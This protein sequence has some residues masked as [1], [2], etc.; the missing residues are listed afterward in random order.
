MTM[1]ALV[2]PEVGKIA[3]REKNIPEPGPDDVLVKTTA[4]LVCTSDIH[5]VNGGLPVADGVTLG[6]EAAGV[7]AAVGANVTGFREGDRVLAPAVTPC[8]ECRYC[9]GGYPSQ[10]GGMLGGYRYTAQVDGNMSEYFIVP[11]ARANLA[12]IPEGVSDSEAVYAA[13]MLSTGFMGAENAH[14]RLGDTVAVFAMGPVGLSAVIGCALQGASRIFAVETR[15]ERQKLA[16]IY[17]ATDII[18]FEEGDPVQQILAATSGEGVDAA[19]E[20]LGSPHTWEACVRVTKPGGRISNVGYHGES[21]EP[22]RIPLD[23]Y[24]L[25]MADKS[26][27]GGLCPGGNDRM[28]R[29]LA[30]IEARRF[31]PTHMTT[32]QFSFDDVETAFRMMKTKEDNIIKPLI[33]F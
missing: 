22:L 12:P 21:R 29:I 17:G 24:G 6:H 11:K 18:D 9:Q 2:M 31:D 8:W 30:L 19:I 28:Q 10:C 15:P 5:T 3:I 27:Y 7:V 14:L 33:T 32:H 25:G 13:D 1:K 4:A 23:A 16:R 20:A 26:I